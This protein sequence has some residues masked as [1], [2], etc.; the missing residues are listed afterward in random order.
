MRFKHVK[1]ILIGLL[2]EG[3]YSRL[4]LRDANNFG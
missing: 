2:L 4:E 1:A 3:I